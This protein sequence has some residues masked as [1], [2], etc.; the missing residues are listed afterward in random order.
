MPEITCGDCA[1]AFNAKRANAKYC[2]TCRTYRDLLYQKTAT[3]KCWACEARFC[4]TKRGQIVCAACGEHEHKR[5]HCAFCE[6][7]DQPLLQDGLAVCTYCAFDPANRQMLVRAV[8][9]KREKLMS[10]P[11]G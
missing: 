3:T 8:A 11:S 4:P 10:T 2:S 6:R 5:G 9:K 1:T 7:D